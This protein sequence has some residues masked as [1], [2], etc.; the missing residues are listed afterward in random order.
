M[1]RLIEVA[2]GKWRVDRRQHKPARSDL[3]L[4]YIISDIMDPVEQ[5]DGRF[6]TSKRQY[7]AVGRAHGLIEVG[8]EKQKPKSRATADRAVKESRRQSIRT[9]LEKF[10]AG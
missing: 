8:N 5:V 9:A 3:P 2:P 6:Y 7:R 4:P 1:V 10:K